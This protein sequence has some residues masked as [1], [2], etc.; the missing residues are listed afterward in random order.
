MQKWNNG[1]RG[2]IV[3]KIIEDNF[4]ILEAR[5]ARLASNYIM[6]FDLPDWSSGVI[7]IPYSQY[8]K[9]TPCVDLYMK[10][11]DGYSLVFGGYEIKNNGIELHSDMAYKGRVVIR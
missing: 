2:D 7:F 1:E 6:D 9:P 5:T 11:V 10:T 4:D 8:N 3:K